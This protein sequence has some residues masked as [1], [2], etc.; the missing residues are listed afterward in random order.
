MEFLPFGLLSHPSFYP[1]LAGVTSP[2][3]QPRTPADRAKA[4]ALQL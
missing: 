3:L 1:A 4:L 2:G